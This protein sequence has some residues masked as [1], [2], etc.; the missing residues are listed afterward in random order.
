[1]TETTKLFQAHQA[2]EAA[3]QEGDYAI[4]LQYAA[5]RA[6]AAWIDAV[7]AARAEWMA[8]P[9][10]PAKFSA[11][12]NAEDTEGCAEDELRWFQ[13]ALATYEMNINDK[14]FA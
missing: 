6:F 12:T 7:K 13:I 14:D 2:A 10:G 3:M 1:M 9:E 4:E 8:L 11:E 5:D